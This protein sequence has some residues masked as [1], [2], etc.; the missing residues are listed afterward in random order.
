[1]NTKLSKNRKFRRM[2][3]NI[4][5]IVAILALAFPATVNVHAE[6]PIFL[7]AFPDGNAV[8]GGN[9]PL[10]ATVHMAI[11]DPATGAGPDWEDDAVVVAS[12]E[13]WISTYVRFDFDGAYDLKP[14]DE[15]ALSAGELLRYLV[16]PDLRVTRIDPEANIV[17]GTIEPYN[18]VE[19]YTL[20]HVF[21]GEDAQLYVNANSE[22]AWAVH[23]DDLEFDLKAGMQGAVEVWFDDFN[24]S[25]IFNWTNPHFTVFPEW[26]FFDGL[27]WPDEAT[28]SITVTG[29]PECETEK[30]SWGYFFN[31]NFGEGCDIVLGDTVTFTDGTTT[32]SHEVQN[33]SVAT[34]NANSDIVSGKADPGTT[35]Y[36][37]PHGAELD[38]LQAIAHKVTGSWMA[39]FKEVPFDLAQRMGGRSEVRDEYGNST[40]VDWEAK[41][42]SA[43]LWIVAYTYDTP[44]G[45]WEEGMHAYQFELDWTIP[46]PGG[47]AG[48]AGEF[49]VSNDASLY[50]GNVLLRGPS[51]LHRVI[52]PGG[53]VCEDIDSFH[54]DQ[55]TRFLVGWIPDYEMTYADARAYFDSISARVVWDDGESAELVPHE[56]RPFSFESVDVWLKYAC[57]FTMRK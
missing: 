7:R 6:E 41:N 47:F 14:G 35:V 2:F 52:V 10:G 44:A 32:L 31:G 8:D 9:W 42:S 56:L 29:K 30:E 50:E 18:T 28:V 5:N 46:E 3:A 34:A 57:T 40:A 23:F 15:V 1:M 26:E 25:T 39:D 19:P 37:W 21:I 24:D 49:F 11:D 13:G 51:T 36:V 43:G 53:A 17:A 22:G 33:L 48:Q 16:V 45:F 38:L 27:D 55:P 54:P 4:L 12:D 20:V